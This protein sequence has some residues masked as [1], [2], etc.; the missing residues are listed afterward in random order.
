[1]EF[2]KSVKSLA[3]AIVTA[4]I[5]SLLVVASPIAATAEDCPTYDFSKLFFE[6]Y[7]PGIK[8]DNRNPP[9]V[10]TWT[11]EVTSIEGMAISRR[12]TEQESQWLELSFKSWDDA[13]DSIR[14]ERR[15]SAAGVNIQVGMVSIQNNGYWTVEL[16]GQFRSSGTIQ[17]SSAST[18]LN[19]RDG[20]IETAQSEIGNLLGL[21]DIRE[22]EPVD[23]V[24]KD[25]DTAPFGSVPLSDFD[26]GMIRQFYGESTC[27]S[28]WSQSL[29]DQKTE[30]KRIADE[31]AK[32]K[33]DQER[34]AAEAKAQAEAAA[35]DQ[36][37]QQD[38]EAKLRAKI[39]K[40]KKTTITCVK[41]KTVRKVT[42]VKPK[43]PPGF[44]LKK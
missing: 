22:A 24:M 16:A 9:R 17:L 13:L 12:F 34:A 25:P 42:A 26:I 23:S 19:T 2:A 29:K 30:A 4:L 3:G 31:E 43:C 37:A 18:F 36:K 27:P 10:I 28:T 33:A 38:L 41:G 6:E 21:G 15:S 39:V 32:A 20:F 1:M 35:R 11:T 8:W 40:P 5:S 44:K 14:F 7:Y